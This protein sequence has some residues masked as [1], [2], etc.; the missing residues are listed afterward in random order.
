VQ[1]T[2]DKRVRLIKLCSQV[3]DMPRD[4]FEILSVLPGK[5]CGSVGAVILTEQAPATIL[6]FSET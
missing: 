5:I 2:L 6:A 3:A 1:E 4:F